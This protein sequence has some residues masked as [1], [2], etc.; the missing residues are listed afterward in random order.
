MVIN[1]IYIMIYTI[2]ILH[3]GQSC[4]ILSKRGKAVIVLRKPG[5]LDL[6][7]A[8]RSILISLLIK[9]RE[10]ISFT[11]I[12]CMVEY[13]ILYD[14]QSF[15]VCGID[16][17][18]IRKIIR[19]ISGIHFCKIKRMIPMVIITAAIFYNRCNPDC[20]KAKRL[21]VIQFF[22]KTFKISSPLRIIFIIILCSIP[23]LYIIASVSVI[24]T[25]CH[26]KID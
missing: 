20:R 2:H 5:S 22:S 4:L 17:I 1:I 24:K 11:K 6:L 9:N 16:K 21:Y 3:Q 10:K 7:Q 18:L 14:F 19:F 26:N 8:G 25:C 13:D 12:S 15:C 23:A